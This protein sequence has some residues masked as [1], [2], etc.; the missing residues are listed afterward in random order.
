MGAEINGRA[1]MNVS[2]LGFPEAVGWWRGVVGSWGGG[3]FARN[4]GIV[5]PSV[6]GPT[7]WWRSGRV[8]PRD[9]GGWGGVTVSGG[10]R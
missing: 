4:S 9:G 3:G 5:V 7:R 6:T 2:A 8:C 1:R 10:T